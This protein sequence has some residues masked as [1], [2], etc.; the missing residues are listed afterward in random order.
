MKDP[1]QVQV[2]A[3]R[4]KRQ[5]CLVDA[6]EPTNT[7]STVNC[8][9]ER[10]KSPRHRQLSRSDRRRPPQSPRNEAR[11]Q[12]GEREGLATSERREPTGGT[13]SSDHEDDFDS[14]KEENH[15]PEKQKA[16]ISKVDD[17]D[18]KWDSDFVELKQS[19]QVHLRVEAG[20]QRDLLHAELSAESFREGA[21]EYDS[22]VQVARDTYIPPRTT[23][24]V[25]LI[26]LTDVPGTNCAVELS[27]LP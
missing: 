2:L 18:R 8:T 21:P 22:L 4:D 7:L 10:R 17:F 26:Y 15:D 3:H 20:R 11:S 1:S 24:T 25:M 9:T 19:D 27:P 12:G 5:L 13:W 16:H 23:H 14:D 6:M